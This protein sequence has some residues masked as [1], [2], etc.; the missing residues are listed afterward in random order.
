MIIFLDGADSIN[1]EVPSLN[2]FVGPETLVVKE[3]QTIDMEHKEKEEGEDDKSYSS[4][5][6]NPEKIINIV[7]SYSLRK[8]YYKLF[9]L[10]EEIS[11]LIT[12]GQIS[13]SFVCF[14][15]SLSLRHKDAK[16]RNIV[17]FKLEGQSPLLAQKGT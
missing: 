16:K 14:S 1:E 17:L 9:S 11:T 13:Q 15:L 8:T 7:H 12:S 6:P 10:V 5:Y 4:S 3:W 2:S